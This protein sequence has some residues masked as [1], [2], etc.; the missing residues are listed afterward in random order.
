[1]EELVRILSNEEVVLLEISKSLYQHEKSMLSKNLNEMSSTTVALEQLICSFEKLEDERKE[2]FESLKRNLNYPQ[3]ISF[4]KF[5]KQTG[6]T[7]L[8]MVFKIVKL[9]NEI[10]V[11]MDRLKTLS[12]FQLDY[13]DMLISTFSNPVQSTYNGD[14]SLRKSSSHRFEAQS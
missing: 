5:A 14:A 13:I 4:Y 3:E 11:Q 2:C 10:S 9:F 8:E 1:M 12:K 7:I 6:G